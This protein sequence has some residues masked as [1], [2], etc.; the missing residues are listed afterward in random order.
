MCSGETTYKL[1]IRQLLF[2]SAD[3][4]LSMDP[5]NNGNGILEMKI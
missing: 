5:I 1:P 4:E 2:G 3:P